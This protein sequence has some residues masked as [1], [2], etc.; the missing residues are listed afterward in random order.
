MR[1]IHT[2]DCQL[3]ARFAQFGVKADSLRKA[4]LQTLEKVL[5]KAE[6]LAVDAV[7]VAGDLFEDGQVD[8]VLITAALSVFRI[9]PDLPVFVLPGNH[10]PNTGPGSIWNRKPFALK[11]SN[12]TIIH[13]PG[14]YNCGGAHLIASPLRQRVSTIDPSLKIAELARDI[15][16]DRIRI[17]LTHGALAI[18]TRHQPNDFPIA[19]EAAT[20]AGLDYLAVGH[21]HTWQVY[22]GGRLVMP[23]TPEPDGFEQDGA[24]SVAL[25]EIA[26]RRATPTVQQ[27]PVATLQ[28]RVSE[29]DF[30]DAD[31]ARRSL[32]HILTELRPSGDRTVLRVRLRGSVPARVLVETE[33]WLSIALEPFLV[34]QIV[35]QT[36]VTLS[37]AELEELRRSHPLLAQS[38]AD[39]AQIEHLATS[40]PLPG[41]IDPT[42]VIPLLEAQAL[43]INAKI[44]LAKLD[45]DFFKL[46]HRLFSQTL[47]GAAR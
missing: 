32:D 2:A 38:I 16:D 28:W 18:P 11:P 42:Q 24:G 3:G 15:A 37:A 29:F 26:T 5:G 40:A 36:A 44:E 22:D 45:V 4:R 23:G 46:A 41:D 25:V 1:F 33:Q 43:L 34:S 30:T 27:I 17:G 12:V 20:R 10:D 39:L 13:E 21:W 9:F 14:V 19:L 7:L 47:Q 6:E 35:D 31:T 8:D